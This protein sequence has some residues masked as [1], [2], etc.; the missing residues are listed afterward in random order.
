VLPSAAPIRFA[1][2]EDGLAIG[3]TSIGSG[4]PL[5][6]THNF[7]LSHLEHEWTVPSLAAFDLGL[8][9]HHRVIRF[10]P[11]TA[12]TSATGTVPDLTTAGMCRD[13]LA[14]ADAAGAE[15]F[16]LMAVNTMGPVGIEFAAR[17]PDRITH[18]I[19]CD[20]DVT[21]ASTPHARLIKA[22]SALAGIAG[23][24][25]ISSIWTVVTP[26][27]ER[28]AVIALVAEAIRSQDQPSVLGAIMEWDAAG[29]LEKVTAPTL[30]IAG[31]GTTS[32]SPEQTRQIATSIP[33]TEVYTI[34]SLLAP[35][36]GGRGEALAAIGHFLGWQHVSADLSASRFRTVVFTDIVGSTEMLGALGDT[37]GRTAMRTV[38]AAID[39][40]VVTHAGSVVKHLGDGTLLEFTSASD[41][42]EFA[43]ELQRH[44]S[45]GALQVRIGMAAG[46]PVREAGDLH[47]AVVVQASRVAGLA[48]AG[49]TVATDSVRQLVLGK[50]FVFKALGPQTLK[51]FDQPV[52]VWRLVS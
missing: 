1:R 11:R 26:A 37:A 7:G 40:L 10:D 50:D 13:I 35:Y 28:D 44:L 48:G 9:E 15:R 33:G 5:I 25:L 38:E 24:E 41:A 29:S 42:L 20:P 8:A 36:F 31:R 45:P 3:Y 16:V 27:E 30:V 34:N 32:S 22:Q 18:L 4:P 23:P 51:G 43:A 49:E 46:E 6:I 17:H 2:T 14:V 21:T 52:A 19:L 12:G 39:Q 47:G